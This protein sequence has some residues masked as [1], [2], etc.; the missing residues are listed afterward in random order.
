MHEGAYRCLATVFSVTKIGKCEENVATATL[1]LD[2]RTSP[3]A[4]GLISRRAGPKSSPYGPKIK[5]KSILQS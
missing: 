5:L 1:P 4:A 2:S 3:R